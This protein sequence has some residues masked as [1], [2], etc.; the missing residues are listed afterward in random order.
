M[1]FLQAQRVQN[2]Y[3]NYLQQLLYRSRTGGSFNNPPYYTTPRPRTRSSKKVQTITTTTTTEKP[4]P[5]S[6]PASR[7]AAIIER[8]GGNCG[9]R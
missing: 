1:S 9:L 8:S 4:K 6:S 3:Q 2:Y 5:A 7:L